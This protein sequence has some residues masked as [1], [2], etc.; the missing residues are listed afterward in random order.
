MDINTLVNKR[1]LKEVT[2]EIRKYL[3]TNGNENTIYPNF[4]DAAKAVLR[5]KLYQ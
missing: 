2:R 4:G 5:E 1:W 3:E